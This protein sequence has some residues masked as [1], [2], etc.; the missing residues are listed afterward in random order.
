MVPQASYA[1][2][3]SLS[4]FSHE[5]RLTKIFTVDT[6]DESINHIFSKGSLKGETWGESEIEP[7]QIISWEYPIVYG[8]KPK[9]DKNPF[10]TFLSFDL[11]NGVHSSSAH[12]ERTR[13]YGQFFICKE[14]KDYE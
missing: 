6:K 4:C 2:K 13:P 3:F 11:A 14:L 9:S 1:M 7:I 12:K 10:L 5:S 8:Y